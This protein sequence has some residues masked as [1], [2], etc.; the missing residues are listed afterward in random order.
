[1]ALGAI[2]AFQENHIRIPEDIAIVGMD[3]VNFV[4]FLS[5]P[6][7]SIYMAQR[8]MGRCGAEFLFRRLE[9]DDSPSQKIIF[10]PKLIIR[11]SSS[12]TRP[13]E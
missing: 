4:K 7:S 9:G 11:Q 12:F 5:P 13:P 3:D 10:Q 2:A 1:M 8:D 6:L